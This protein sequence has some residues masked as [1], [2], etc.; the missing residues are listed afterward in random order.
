VLVITGYSETAMAREGFL[1][2]GMHLICKPFE[3]KEIK[4]HVT[5]ILAES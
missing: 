5:R 1:D 4:A 2:A 3:L